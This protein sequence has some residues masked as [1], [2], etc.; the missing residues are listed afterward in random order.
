VHKIWKETTAYF[1][2]WIENPKPWAAAMSQIITPF[3]KNKVDPILQIILMQTLKEKT[4]LLDL[5]K[6]HPT[7][8]FKP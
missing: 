3:R 1:L 2:Q 8:D 7:V 5:T 6:S 4:T